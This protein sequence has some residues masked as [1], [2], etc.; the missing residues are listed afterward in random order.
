MQ[1]IKCSDLD[2]EWSQRAFECA[3]RQIDE[4]NA[5]QQIARVLL[6][7]FV[8]TARVQPI[9]NFILK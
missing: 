9:P 2:G 6:T 1:S 5:A 3:R 7:I 4:L 8:G